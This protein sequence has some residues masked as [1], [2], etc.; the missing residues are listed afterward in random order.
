LTRDLSPKK[1]N[2]VEKKMTELHCIG[3][4][5]KIDDVCKNKTMEHYH[6]IIVIEK[7]IEDYRENG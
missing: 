7:L 5:N 4:I 3:L 6:R 1:R 2:G